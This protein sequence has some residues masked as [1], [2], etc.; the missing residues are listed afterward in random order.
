MKCSDSIN[1]IA[2]ALAAAQ[3]EFLPIVKTLTGKIT[4]TSEYKYAPLDAVLDATRP[5]LN[6]HGISL[7]QPSER[8]DKY[9]V[10]TTRLIHASGQWIESSL[11]MPCENLSPQKIGIAITYARRYGLSSL[12]GVASEFD[13]DAQD[14]R[15][16]TPARREERPQRQED[17]PPQ[18]APK[19][20]PKADPPKPPKFDS[21]RKDAAGK[22]IPSIKGFC[23][24]ILDIDNTTA[25]MAFN[26]R[27]IAL[28][29]AGY[30]KPEEW[31]VYVK[32]VDA[33]GQLL[34]AESA[35]DREPGDDPE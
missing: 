7:V 11:A 31:T 21:D 4:A 1:E 16:A 33:R 5:A 24:L 15:P 6:K 3:A 34:D 28:Y 8:D 14:E 32:A 25:L 29:Q 2:K 20:E 18:P 22:P 12:I 27:A 13:D 23:D 35:P 26:Q 9:A 19:P 30:Y 10:V 17:R